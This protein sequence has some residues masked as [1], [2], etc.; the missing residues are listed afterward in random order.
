MDKTAY[1]GIDP[2]LTGAV[3]GIRHEI[4]ECH[5]TPTLKGKGSRRLYD[6]AAMTRLIASFED[7]VF[8]VER[9]QAWPGQGVSST[10]KTGYGFGLWVGILAGLAVPYRTV[11]PRTWQ[12]VSCAGIPAGDSKTRT[13]LAVQARFPGVDL[14]ATPRCRKPH[15]GI[16]DA[17]G[18]A[19]YGKVTEGDER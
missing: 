8:F 5:V 6:E 1:V 19:W 11:H 17:L 7:A 13:L 4:I 18:I 16:V 15:E 12:K 9:Q 10:F 14:L 3:V 2:G